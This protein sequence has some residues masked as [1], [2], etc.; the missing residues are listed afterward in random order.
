M[1]KA[2][3]AT[4]PNMQVACGLSHTV[5]CTDNGKVWTFGAGRQG[6]LGTNELHEN[7][8]LPVLISDPK[9]NMH[10]AEEDQICSKPVIEVATGSHHSVALRQD[11]RV[12][13]W[14]S[15]ANGRLGHGTGGDMNNKGE[16][17]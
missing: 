17:L 5:V 12:Y 14:G 11:G 13:S 16:R 10:E 3:G 15:N 1:A 2:A 8:D 6:Q 7:Q 4:V 9:N